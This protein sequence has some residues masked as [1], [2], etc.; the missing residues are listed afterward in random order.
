MIEDV[1]F[2]DTY[3]ASY[4]GSTTQVFG[5]AGYRLELGAASVTPFAGVAYINTSTDGFSETGGIGALT[6][7]GQSAEQT[8]ASL[9]IRA[10]GAFEL[11]EMT[12]ALHGSLAWRH[13][14][15]DLAQT[16]TLVLQGEEFVVAG[17]PTAQD[18]ALVEAGLDLALSDS[19]T[20]GVS[21]SG[22]ITES[23]TDQSVKGA[24][25]VKF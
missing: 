10:E 23:S 7:A 2:A 8:Y 22:V 16:A 4:G 25:S 15:G 24:L 9:G 20:V 13:A 21:Y 19:A 3:D 1:D 17:V 11:G 12:A 18:A 6:A 5:E 14:F